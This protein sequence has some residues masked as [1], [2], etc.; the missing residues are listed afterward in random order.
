[1]KQKLILLFFIT[2]FFTLNLSCD[3]NNTSKSKSIA[4]YKSSLNDWNT[5]KNLYENSYK[6]T[7]SSSS[8]FGFGTNTTITIVNNIVISRM[9]EAFSVFDKNNN[10]IG[11]EN[12]LVFESYTENAETLN[13]HDSGAI[14]VTIDALYETCLSA[15]LSVDSDSNSITFNVDNNN[16]IKDCYYIPNGCQDDCTFGIKISSFQWLNIA[17]N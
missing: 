4:K 9:Y 16:L 2:S 10:Y 17:S 14:A 12:R 11:Y 5:L 15:Y 7:V 3:T 13:E 1:M 6:Y 8:V